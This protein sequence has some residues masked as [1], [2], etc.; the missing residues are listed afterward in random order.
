MVTGHHGGVEH[1]IADFD[2]ETLGKLTQDDKILIRAYGQG[3][4]LTDYP[5][6]KVSLIGCLK[7]IQKM[8]FAAAGLK[9]L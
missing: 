7:K 4:S 5:E 9:C 6:I 3:L 8:H 2:D 1:V